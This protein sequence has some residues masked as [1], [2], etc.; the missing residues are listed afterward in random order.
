APA[1][2]GA[3]ATA[4]PAPRPTSRPGSAS[5]PSPAASRPTASPACR[6]SHDVGWH[7]PLPPP[8]PLRAGLSHMSKELEEEWFAPCSKPHFPGNG[9]VSGM[10]PQ[11]IEGNST[12]DRKILWSVILARPS[13]VFV[14]DNIELPMQVIFH[15]PVSTRDFKN[16]GGRQ[17]PGQGN[18]ARCH[19]GLLAHAPALGLDAGQGD[20]ARERRGVGR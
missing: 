18:V 2:P 11:D 10:T 5:A 1:W 8:P 20:Q 4:A 7:G 19:L 12:N 9:L 16:P 6:N 13:V 14:E 17:T 15:T 3:P